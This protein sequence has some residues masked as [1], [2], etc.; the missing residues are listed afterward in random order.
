MPNDCRG[1]CI[2]SMA[3][4]AANL[5]FPFSE[6][7]FATFMGKS[8]IATFNSNMLMIL[9]VLILVFLVVTCIGHMNN[10]NNR[11][12]LITAVMLVIDMIVFVYNFSIFITL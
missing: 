6:N 2:L 4:G 5:A 11:Y 7:H 1:T 9:S 8:D 12:F 10:R 3:L